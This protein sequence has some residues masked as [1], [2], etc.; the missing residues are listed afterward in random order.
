MSAAFAD[1]RVCAL[2]SKL[3]CLR[4]PTPCVRTRARAQKMFE[5]FLTLRA[6]CFMVGVMKM[7]TLSIQPAFRDCE[8]GR[9]CVRYCG[10]H[11]REQVT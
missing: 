10:L 6:S 8:T 5:P 7:W 11:N 4:S 9:G 1:V 2:N 3:G